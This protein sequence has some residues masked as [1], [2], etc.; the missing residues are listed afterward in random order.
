MRKYLFTLLLAV[1]GATAQAVPY[2]YLSFCTT[3]GA[4]ASFPLDGIDLA[5][6]GNTLR[7]GEET[8]LIGNLSRMYFSDTDD[9]VTG[10]A[11]VQTT[12]AVDPSA[13]VYDL[14]G[15][16]V[17]ASEMTSGVYLVKTQGK[18]C[19]IIVR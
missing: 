10:I 4:I 2:R 17:S 13:T 11:Q 14:H 1:T 19:K 8:L 9:T 6:E 7:V 3:D 15:K 5:I 12:Q 16:K 18:T